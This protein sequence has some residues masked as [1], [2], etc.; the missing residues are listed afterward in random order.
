M[1]ISWS[2]GATTYCYLKCIVYDKLLK[3]WQALR[4]TLHSLSAVYRFNYIYHKTAV[5]TSHLSFNS[6]TL[7]WNRSSYKPI[8]IINL[9]CII[10]VPY[11]THP[12]HNIRSPSLPAV[13]KW[14]SRRISRIATKH[15]PTYLP[16]YP[17][18]CSTGQFIFAFSLK[19]Y[20]SF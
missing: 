12:L 9:F 20:S 13:R 17:A 6:A 16:P 15:L 8:C 11:D 14:F 18:A 4:T 19:Q 2:I 3:P 5:R 10:S 1:R 7:R